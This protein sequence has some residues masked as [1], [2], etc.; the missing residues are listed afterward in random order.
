M[1]SIMYVIKKLYKLAV[2][3]FYIVFIL[4]QFNHK[5]VILLLFVEHLKQVPKSTVKKEENDTR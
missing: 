1:V 3:I 5:Y 4:L 2:F